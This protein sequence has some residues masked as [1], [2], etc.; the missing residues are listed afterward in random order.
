MPPKTKGRNGRY[1][2]VV[3]DDHPIMRQ[4]L[5]QLINN[6]PDLSV[7]R[8]AENARQALEAISAEKPDMVLVDITLPDKDGVELIKDIRA[9]HPTL[10]ILVLSMHDES[11]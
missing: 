5:V 8:E 6:E 2:L 7:C 11:L 9:Q 1:R 3:V 10:A 4:G